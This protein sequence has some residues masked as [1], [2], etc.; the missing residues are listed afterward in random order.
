[1]LER[2]P[3]RGKP[4]AWRLTRS[5]FAHRLRCEESHKRF[6]I[7]AITGF[8]GLPKNGNGV[9]LGEGCRDANNDGEHHEK[10]NPDAVDQL[11]VCRMCAR[12]EQCV[13]A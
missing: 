1:M 8:D 12:E 9:R 5:I 6:E 13:A 3:Y 2:S 4:D 11:C 10:T 7:A